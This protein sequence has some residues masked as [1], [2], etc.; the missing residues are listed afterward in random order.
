MEL[1]ECG[2]FLLDLEIDCLD[3]YCQDCCE[4]NYLNDEKIC[5]NK[6]CQYTRCNATKE[7]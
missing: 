2:A 5:T 1:C 3:G 6:K 4:E 7:K